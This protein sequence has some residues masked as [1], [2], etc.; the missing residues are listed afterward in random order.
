MPPD[1][2]NKK[3]RNLSMAQNTS[4]PFRT[5]LQGLEDLRDAQREYKSILKS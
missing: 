1:M 2:F 5:R 3:S 4:R